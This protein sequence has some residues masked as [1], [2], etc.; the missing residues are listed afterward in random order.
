MAGSWWWFEGYFV[1]GSPWGW[2]DLGEGDESESLTSPLRMTKIRRQR[3]VCSILWKKRHL[4]SD[5]TL[6]SPAKKDC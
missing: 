3:R 6:N 2:V 5:I 4:M 1:V